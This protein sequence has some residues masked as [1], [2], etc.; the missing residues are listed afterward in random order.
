MQREP[1]II[2]EKRTK[3]FVLI[4]GGDTLETTDQ[5]HSLN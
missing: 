2:V 1:Q 5:G 4:G 3:T